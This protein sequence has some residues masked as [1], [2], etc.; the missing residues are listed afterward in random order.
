[1]LSTNMQLVLLKTGKVFVPQ[2]ELPE[3]TN[4]NYALSINRNLESYGYSLDLATIKAISTHPVSDIML[5][6]QNIDA[7]IRDYKGINEFNSVQTFYPNFPEEVMRKDEMELYLN[8]IL[9][10]AF[11]QT[12]DERMTAIAQLIR[13]S[14]TEEE[15]QRLPL[16][17]EL[18]KDRVEVLSLTDK[19]EI[20]KIMNARIHGMG[21]SEKDMD[22]LLIYREEFPNEF[23]NAV[24][25]NDKFQSKEVLVKLMLKLYDTDSLG[26]ETIKTM[27]R[28][29]KDV[30]RFAAMLSNRNLTNYENEI[31]LKKAKK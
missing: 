7:T 8:S 10:Y 5:I 23:Y 24:H 4:L 12:E 6:Y 17:T 3:G 31:N 16:M 1:M 13:D 22:E 11:S 28:D 27:L 2:G 15:M 9:Y 14:V 19:N 30:I 20:H 26:K 25:S 29:T 21:M 18:Y